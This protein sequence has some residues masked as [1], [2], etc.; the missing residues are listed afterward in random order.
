MHRMWM[1]TLMHAE[2]A[3][4]G[5][6]RGGHLAMHCRARQ[7]MHSTCYYTFSSWGGGGGPT[8]AREQAQ[9]AMRRGHTRARVWERVVP[10][11]GA[12]FGGREMEGGASYR[13]RDAGS[14]AASGQARRA[15]REDNIMGARALTGAHTAWRGVWAQRS[16]HAHVATK[17]PARHDEANKGC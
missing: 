13:V 2:R 1:K 5:A 7:E 16:A 10:R 6:G 17:W 14:A 3:R 11:R 12:E 15:S 9:G 8:G 4:G